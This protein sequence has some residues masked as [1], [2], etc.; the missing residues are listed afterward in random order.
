MM[1]NPEILRAQKRVFSF[2]YGAPVTFHVLIA[3]AVKIQLSTVCTAIRT[4]MNRA[5]CF[6]MMT[7]ASTIVRAPKNPWTINNA[8]ITAA[9]TELNFLISTS[10]KQKQPRRT[11]GTVRLFKV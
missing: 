8:K 10:K 1:A 4:T 9:R 2:K 3:F 5:M 6:V 11:V 7:A